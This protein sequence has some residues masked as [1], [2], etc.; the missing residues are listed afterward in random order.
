MPSSSMKMK[1]EQ[2]IM[3]FFLNTILTFYFNLILNRF[4]NKI[5]KNLCTS[6]VLNKYNSRVTSIN[7]NAF[8][9]RSQTSTDNLYKNLTT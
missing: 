1:S 2:L 5:I 6:I 9:S 8:I 4:T 7:V 3:D